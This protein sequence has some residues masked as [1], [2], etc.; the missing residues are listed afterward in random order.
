M[1]NF[2]DVFDRSVAKYDSELDR[3]V[4]LFAQCVLGLLAVSISVVGMDPLQ[5]RFPAR[6]ALQ[7]IKAPDAEGLL[8]PI[9]NCRLAIDRG[10]GAAQPLCFRQMGFAAAQGFLVVAKRH[11]GSFAVL[12]VREN[13][14]PL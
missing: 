11:F 13:L 14:V 6:K 9:K 1:V 10:A 5:H 7:R 8:R 3:T 2:F 12:Y 4:S